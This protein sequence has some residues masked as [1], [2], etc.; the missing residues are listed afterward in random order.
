[1]HRKIASEHTTGA[2][3]LNWA[4][5]GSPLSDRAMVRRVM[6]SL[7]R[8][9]TLCRRRSTSARLALLGRLRPVRV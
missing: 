1:M 7:N 9:Q 3:L 6:T 5:A 8:P 4:R 2:V